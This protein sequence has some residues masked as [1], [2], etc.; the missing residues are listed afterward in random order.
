MNFQEGCSLLVTHGEA[1]HQNGLQH[2]CKL[3]VHTKNEKCLP[4]N[5]FPCKRKML[6]IILK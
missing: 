3:D 6:Q 5:I 4:D 1:T 2:L